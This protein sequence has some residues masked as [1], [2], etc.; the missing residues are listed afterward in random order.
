MLRASAVIPEAQEAKKG[1]GVRWEVMNAVDF[2]VWQGHSPKNT[3]SLMGQD[4]IEKKGPANSPCSL[5][6]TV[7]IWFLVLK[8]PASSNK[9]LQP[10]HQSVAAIL[11]CLAPGQGF[12]AGARR[13]SG[14]AV[15]G[16]GPRGSGGPAGGSRGGAVHAGGRGHWG[17]R[18]CWIWLV[19]SWK[20]MSQ[21]VK[22]DDLRT[23]KWWG[24][25]WKQ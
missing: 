24:M 7:Y 12:Q 14:G 13:S 22:T 1:G 2:F 6:P 18:G 11:S 19:S 15:H 21:K 16:R 10:V 20:L 3:M 4:W 23:W 9:N 8:N 17:A 5:N 25:A